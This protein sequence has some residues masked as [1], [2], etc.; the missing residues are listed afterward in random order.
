MGTQLSKAVLRTIGIA[1]ATVN[2]FEEELLACGFPDQVTVRKLLKAVTEQTVTPP[3]STHETIY[4]TPLESGDIF[5]CLDTQSRN[6]IVSTIGAGK[7]LLLA[8]TVL[9]CFLKGAIE[10]VGTIAPEATIQS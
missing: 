10:T 2:A 1:P 5:L 8:F 9:F 4:N 3:L 6:T 7:A